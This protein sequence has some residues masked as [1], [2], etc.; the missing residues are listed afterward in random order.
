[1]NI[2]K[3]IEK[4]QVHSTQNQLPGKA[5][6]SEEPISASEVNR[7]LG[8][9]S[10]L[11]L[12]EDPAEKILA[13][14][15]ITRLLEIETKKDSKLLNYAEVVMS[16][17]GNFPGRQLLRKRYNFTNNNVPSFLKLE[18]LSREIE[19]SVFIDGEAIQ[20]TDFQY[21]FFSSLQKETALSISAPT[22][23]GKSFVLGLSL[24]NK[25]R[26]KE[27]QCIVYVVPT[28][29][30]ITEVSS[31]VRDSIR[32]YNLENIIVRTAPFSISKEKAKNGVVY[33]LTQERLM[34][35]LSDSAEKMPVITSLIVDEAHEIQKGK[36]GIL[37]QSAIDYLLKKYPKT[38]VLFASPLIKNP[39][40]FFRIFNI[41]E[42]STFFTETI[43]PVS[44]NIILVSDVQ[45]KTNEINF[46]LI[47]EGKRLAL[48]NRAVDFKFRGRKA[49]Q[50]ANL[51]HEISR[52]NESVIVFANGPSDAESVAK[53]ISTIV[54]NYIP[55]HEVKLFI[56]FLRKEI[57]PEYPLIECL[58][59]GVGFHYGKMP[60]IVRSGIENL[61]KNDEIKFIC[62]TS[63]LLQ[64]VNLP[65]KHIIIENPKSGNTP[66][67]RSDFLN[68]SGRAG[69]LLKEFH[70][71]IWCIRPSTWE[72]NSYEGDKLQEITSAINSVMDDGGSLIQ[73]LLSENI[74]LEKSI[75]EAEM[76][77][78]KLYQD[79]HY[80]E[81]HT[82]IETY[83][84]DRNSDSL[85]KTISAISKIIVDI[86]PDII[87][88]NKGIRPDYLQ[89]VYDSLASK[90]DITEYLL[91]N[92]YIPGAK[93]KMENVIEIFIDCFEWKVSPSY[94]NL[95]SY[96]SYHWLWG[97][98]L[99][100]LLRTR[101]NF[102]REREPNKKA[103]A[104]IR[105]YLDVLDDDIRFKLVKYFA[106]FNDILKLVLTNKGF[107]LDEIEIEPYHIYLEFGSC[108]KE[109]LNIMA[110]GLSRFTALHLSNFSNAIP[111]TSDIDDYFNKI[112][113]IDVR[114]LKMPRLCKQEIL[115][116]QGKSM[117]LVV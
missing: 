31:M 58:E 47:S 27:N 90:E 98:P 6:V 81:N 74:G 60:S 55:S 11:S 34:S 101:V 18:C 15:I 50:K 92:P 115:S 35:Y 78:S 114:S 30:L 38:E 45:G 36:R 51:A 39:E 14:E 85:D 48:G 29:A 52:N 102:V 25:L 87:E 69:R 65:A 111:D 2:E 5:T 89:R 71:N 75:D 9:T 40:Y 116:M 99:G 20:L 79:Y 59:S 110:T 97:K 57:H 10:I 3:L 67:T 72:D 64:G 112:K 91:V 108:K 105:D 104:I 61:F 24:T 113:L 33:V 84:T 63:T 66:M 103:S 117:R 54:D 86:P 73:S 94:K 96:L 95:I 17:L 8:H 32:K 109:A 77:F 56:D 70:G 21:D 22:S 100:E 106:A 13:Y 76:A 62:C 46:Q 12:S 49:V 82:A 83:R 68:L 88:K 43:S 42:N 7:L 41:S 53:E 19:N 23:A 4:L 1:M 16:R 44:Q 26:E 93:T 28:R 80:S 37:L 107:N